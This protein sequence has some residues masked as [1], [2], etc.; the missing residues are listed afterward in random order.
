MTKNRNDKEFKKDGR[1]TEV[2]LSPEGYENLTSTKLF[3]ES[4]A[5]GLNDL[6]SGNVFTTKELKKRLL[7]NKTSHH[8]Q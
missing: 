5:R 7:K 1:R 2:V 3:K 8:N 6:E 4:V